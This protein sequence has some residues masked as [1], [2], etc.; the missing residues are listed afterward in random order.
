MEFR[1]KCN[2]RL[3]YEND[4]G[5]Q[6]YAVGDRT[7]TCERLMEKTHRIIAKSV[8]GHMDMPPVMTSGS[9]PSIYCSSASVPATYWFAKRK[10]RLRS[11]SK[12]VEKHLGLLVT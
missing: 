5:D 4:F 3:D 6:C 12:D 11:V 10:L 7:A 1:R 9:E 2:L 8:N